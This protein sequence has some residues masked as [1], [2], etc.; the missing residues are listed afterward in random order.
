[1]N[2][3]NITRHENVAYPH[4]NLYGPLEI[5]PFDKIDNMGPATSMVSNVKD[6]GGMDTVSAG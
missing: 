3:A 2:T 1:M 6:L 4:N 5:I